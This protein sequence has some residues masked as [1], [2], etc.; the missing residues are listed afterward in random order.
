MQPIDTN[1][2]KHEIPTDD[3]QTCENMALTPMFCFFPWTF[4]IHAWIILD[5]RQDVWVFSS[6][7]QIQWVWCRNTWSTQKDFFLAELF[8][9]LCVL[10]QTTINDW[11]QPPRWFAPRLSC[12]TAGVPSAD[13]ANST[14]AAPCFSQAAPF[15]TWKGA[16]SLSQRI[17]PLL[18]V[19][20]VMRQFGEH[21]ILKLG[22]RGSFCN[23]SEPRHIAATWRLWLG[24]FKRPSRTTLKPCYSWVLCS[25][26][27]IGNGHVM[28]F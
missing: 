27:V 4:Q 11:P 17:Y 25:T 1:G 20:R 19:M 10:L 28:A 5:I 23:R 16:Q 15:S 14:E 12:S 24:T 18:W 26:M 22:R 9:F 21:R 3:M 8:A 7:G 13:M 2:R 6:T